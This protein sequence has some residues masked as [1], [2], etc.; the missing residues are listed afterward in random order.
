M[1]DS[2]SGGKNECA[3]SLGFP[4]TMSFGDTISLNMGFFNPVSIPENTTILPT[5]MKNTYYLPGSAQ[6]GGVAR[7]RLA[8]D[9]STRPWFQ[10]MS[11]GQVVLGGPNTIRYPSFSSKKETKAVQPCPHAATS[12]TLTASSL[13]VHP[14]FLS[15][16]AL[17]RASC[18]A[19]FP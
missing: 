13:Q 3:A 14:L 7:R 16:Q 9:A 11:F 5:L 12:L 18:Q 15:P 6:C 8:Q 2:P 4:P 19:L 1:H 10:G 17:H